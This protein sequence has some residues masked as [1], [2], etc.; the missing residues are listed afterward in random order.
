M[1]NLEENGIQIHSK[2]VKQPD[3]LFIQNP[4]LVQCNYLQGFFTFFLKSHFLMH[5]FFYIS[6]SML[7]SPHSTT[8]ECAGRGCQ[9]HHSSLH[10]ERSKPSVHQ[11]HQP[12]LQGD[13]SFCC[14]LVFRATTKKIAVSVAQFISIM[15]Q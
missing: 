7:Y 2:S 11:R 9:L 13:P 8:R 6:H 5:P 10:V 14:P 1:T 15:P 12:G 4:Y 3:T